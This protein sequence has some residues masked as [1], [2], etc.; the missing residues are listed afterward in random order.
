MTFN[1]GLI[2]Q[3]ENI[4][5]EPH[6]RLNR[7]NTYIRIFNLIAV[8][9]TFFCNAHEIFSNIVHILGYTTSLNIFKK[10]GII[11]HIVFNHNVIKLEINNR[12][13]F[14]KLTTM[15]KLNSTIQTTNGSKKKSKE[16]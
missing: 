11:S 3:A 5:L 16:K 9:Y 6:F 2:N 1:S 14:G 15:W 7:L 13:N 12:R 8:E 4:E 10:T